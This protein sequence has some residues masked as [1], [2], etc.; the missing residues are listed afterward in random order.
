VSR[1]VEFPPLPNFALPSGRTRRKV[2]RTVLASGPSPI[3]SANRATCSLASSR[4]PESPCGSSKARK[5]DASDR[6]LPSHVFVRAPTPRRLPLVTCLDTREMDN[7]LLH[8]SATDFGG[9]HLRSVAAE[10]LAP[11]SP[12]STM[13]PVLARRSQSRE[14]PRP[15]AGV[16]VNESPVGTIRSA[17]HLTRT[18]ALQ[19]S[20]ERPSRASSGFA[21]WPPR[22]RSSS[23][24]TRSG[25]LSRNSSRACSRSRG[26]LP[27]VPRFSELR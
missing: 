22:S 27:P 1:A 14:P 12:L 24:L 20:L 13:T 9:P 19:R 26:P 11:L 21:A 23:P 2:A 3:A 5:R 16:R 10:P 17:F 4:A 7:R 8:I 25:S 6:L 18:L 15:S